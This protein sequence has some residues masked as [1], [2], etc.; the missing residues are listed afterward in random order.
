MPPHCSP[1]L[2]TMN[3]KG[4]DNQEI[5]KHS[6]EY[7]LLKWLEHVFFL[8]YFQ[9]TRIWIILQSLC[10]LKYLF[11]YLDGMWLSSFTLLQ[12]PS[13]LNDMVLYLISIIRNNEYVCRNLSRKTGMSGDFYRL[14]AVMSLLKKIHYQAIDTM[15]KS[16]CD[17][18]SDW[19]CT[20][21][22]SFRA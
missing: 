4:S 20:T 1:L 18:I 16:F 5:M 8:R 11:W 13:P 22:K 9:N 21:C 17:H 2:V 10:S 6:Q 3:S 15:S 7:N 12:S 14:R 19:L